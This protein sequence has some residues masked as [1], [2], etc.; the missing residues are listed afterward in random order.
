MKEDR[1]IKASVY[2]PSYI[3]RKAVDSAE[4]SWGLRESEQRKK[5]RAAYKIWTKKKQRRLISKGLIL[6]K[7]QLKQPSI[8]V[9][10]IKHRLD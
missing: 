1:K 5:D 4:E 9:L 6:I 7:I 10:G 3:V 8:E 2:M